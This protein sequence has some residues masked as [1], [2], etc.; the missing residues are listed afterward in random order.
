MIE[1]VNELQITIEI[2]QEFIK[3]DISSQN[4]YLFH[5]LLIEIYDICMVFKAFSLSNI[6]SL[7]ICNSVNVICNHFFENIPFYVQF[8][9]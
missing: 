9:Q 8:F 5:T 7:F 6:D 3:F 4:V 1:Y 2:F